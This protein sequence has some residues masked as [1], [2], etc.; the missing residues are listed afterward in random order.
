[1]LRPTTAEDVLAPLLPPGAAAAP[2]LVLAAHPDDETLGASWLLSHGNGCHVVHLTDGAPASPALRS[3]QAPASRQA[4][5]RLRE[6]E[7][8][9]ALELAGLLPAR[10]HQ[11][12]AV[13][14]E[15]AQ[16]LVELSR[17]L[18]A[19]LAELRPAVLVTH[20]YEGGHPDHDAAALVA[21]AAVSLLQRESRLP[22]ALVEMTS[23]HG[24]SGKLQVGEFLPLPMGTPAV[25]SVYLSQEERA[26]KRR[27]LACFGSQA[28]V[29][30]AFPL[31]RERFRAAP[32]YDFS[33]PPH[34]GELYYEVM[35]WGRGAHW[36]EQARQAL[37]ELGLEAVP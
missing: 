25:S 23:Y 35:G 9:A 2:L 12:G 13:D 28:Q 17:R 30:A 6:R 8:Y 37:A 20:P 31:E 27:M 22:L 34:S 3:P 18:V 4:Y 7:A 36:C 16:H 19:L 15:A 11:L 26:L 32:H 29:L 21:R 14:Q 24:R 5:A 33:R 1:M 10:L